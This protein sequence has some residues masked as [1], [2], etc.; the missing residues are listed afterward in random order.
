MN[1]CLFSEYFNHII[2]GTSKLGM[3]SAFNVQTHMVNLTMQ[4]KA[5]K[6]FLKSDSKYDIIIQT[7]V[8]NEGY[9][10]L[11]HHFN[12]RVI[13]FVPFSTMPNIVSLTGNSAPPSYIPLPFLGFTDNMNFFQRTLNTVLS[14]LMTLVHKYYLYPK[15]AQLVKEHFPDFPPLDEIEKEKVDL[16]FSNAHFA[17]ESPRPKTPN[18]VYI[19]GYHVQETQPLTADLQKMLDEAEEGVVFVGFGTNVD[20]KE[21]PKEKMDAF[22]DTFAKIPYK[23]IFKH[24]GILPHKPKNVE[25]IAWLPQKGILGIKPFTI[26]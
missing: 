1:F 19:G 13:G 17:N 6:D 22:L 14:N 24:D 20:P 10:S 9:L 8:L 12:A 16:I 25:T 4:S 2:Q 26:T 15:Q 7:C 23:V 5:M 21:I 3:L 18:I 11:A